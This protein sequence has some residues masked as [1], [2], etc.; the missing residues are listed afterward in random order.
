MAKRY[1]SCSWVLD[2][3]PAQ[4]NG[5]IQAGAIAGYN[6]V[7]SAGLVLV[8]SG[9][10]R[11]IWKVTGSAWEPQQVGAQAPLEVM[12][13]SGDNNGLWVLPLNHTDADSYGTPQG[14]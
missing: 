3:A 10:S 4:T 13:N 1:L 12:V 14:A 11:G 6:Q 5:P 9:A 8:P 2:S 7:V